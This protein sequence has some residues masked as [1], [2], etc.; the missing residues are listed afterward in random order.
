MHKSGAL[1]ENLFWEWE[2]PRVKSNMEHYFFFILP[3]NND[4]HNNSFYF[5]SAF[6]REHYDTLQAELG[7]W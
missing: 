3:L 5:E 6:L 2:I 4:D 7:Q 1:W